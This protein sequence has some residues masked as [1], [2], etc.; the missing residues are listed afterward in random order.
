MMNI[1]IS[2]KVSVKQHDQN[3]CG[4]ACM[5]SVLAYYGRLMHFYA[6]TKNSG[7]RRSVSRCNRSVDQPG[8]EPGTSRL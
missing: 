6:E 4:A 3:D 8:L 5:A 1:K 7:L 2:K